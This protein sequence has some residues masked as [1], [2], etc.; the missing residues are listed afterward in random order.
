MTAR[1]VPR[2]KLVFVTSKQKEDYSG[3]VRPLVLMQIGK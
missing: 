3:S 2:V 1:N